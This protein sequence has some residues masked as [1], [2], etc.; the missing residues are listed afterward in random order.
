MQ[1]EWLLISDLHFTA[2]EAD[3]YRKDLRRQVRELILSRRTIKKVV[4]LGDLT[5]FKNNHSAD[6]VNWITDWLAELAKL[7]VL[8]VVLRGNHDGEEHCPFFLFTNHIP[9]IRYIQTIEEDIAF[10]D[11]N[12]PPIVWLPHSRD[13]LVDWEGLK[14]EGKV[15]MAHVSVD[16]VTSETGHKM[17][18]IVKAELF[19][20]ARLAI[21]GDIHK[22]QQVGPLIYVGSPYNVRFGDDFVG[23]GLILKEGSW[24]IEPVYFK[25]PRKW[26]FH[27]KSIK[28][29]KY[30]VMTAGAE[31]GDMCKVTMEMTQETMGQWRETEKEIYAFFESVYIRCVSCRPTQEFFKLTVNSPTVKQTTYSNFEAFCKARGLSQDIIDA[32]LETIKEVA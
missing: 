18:S 15:V 23:R 13:P 3:A 8:V 26:S 20:G 28:E 10:P 1:D 9:G 30:S 5:E 29:L 32:A 6:L 17:D 16:A 12:H 24:D 21:S 4:I 14:F 19:N 25:F 31:P 11:A 22:P 27:A 7:G 2:R